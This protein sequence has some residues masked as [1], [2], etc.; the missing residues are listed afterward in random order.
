MARSVDVRVRVGFVRSPQ[1]RV[2]DDDDQR[3]DDL[4]DARPGRAL[5]RRNP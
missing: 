5:V 1:H 2:P 3:H 4:P